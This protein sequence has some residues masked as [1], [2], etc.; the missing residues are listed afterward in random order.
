MRR[1]VVA[2]M[3]LALAWATTALAGED[4]PRPKQATGD[5]VSAELAGDV[6]KWQID[7]GQEAGKKTF[8]LA[9]EVKVTYAEKDG[10]KQAQNIRAASGPDR[11]AREGTVVAKGKFA[12]AKLQGE[13][14][15]VTITTEGDKALEVTL[16]KKLSVYYRE[17]EGKVTVFSIGVPRTAR[18]R[19]AGN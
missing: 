2:G 11:P 14:V 10:V 3:V 19:P 5:F 12:S 6:V 16:P 18:P 15:L 13:N 17:E 8:E 1:L 7:Q 4:R 9:A